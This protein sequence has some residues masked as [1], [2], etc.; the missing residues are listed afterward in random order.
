MLKK[1][2][3]LHLSAELCATKHCPVGLHHTEQWL[4]LAAKQVQLK[5]YKQTTNTNCMQLALY[6]EQRADIRSD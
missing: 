2:L 6:V 3:W 1:K 5:S 4:L